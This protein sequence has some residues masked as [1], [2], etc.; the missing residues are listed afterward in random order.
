MKERFEKIAP[1]TSSWRILELLYKLDK[2]ED[3]IAYILKYIC[4]FSTHMNLNIG[5][6]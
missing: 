5:R 2:K 3:D 1:E 4:Y 6:I